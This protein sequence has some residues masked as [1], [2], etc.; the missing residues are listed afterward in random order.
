[1]Q[2]RLQKKLK[3]KEKK[4]VKNRNVFGTLQLKCEKAKKGAGVNLASI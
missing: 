1:M 2:K 4:K 3:E